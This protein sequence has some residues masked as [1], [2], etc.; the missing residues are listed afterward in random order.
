MMI[1]ICAPLL[2]GANVI[3]VSARVG[4]RGVM[5]R[6][7]LT[8]FCFAFVDNAHEAG[9]EAGIEDAE[10]K[11]PRDCEEKDVESKQM[12]AFSAQLLK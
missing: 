4:E 10:I 11:G 9:C 12:R 5:E 7:V 2:L 6:R 1:F 8:C 3:V